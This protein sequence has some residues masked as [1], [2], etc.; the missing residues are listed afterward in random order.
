MNP[1][2]SAS[3]NPRFDY[4]PGQPNLYLMMRHKQEL[5]ASHGVEKGFAEYCATFGLKNARLERLRLDGEREYAIAKGALYSELAAAGE[6]FSHEPPLVIGA[7]NH[8]RIEAISRAQYVACITDA[9]VRGRSALVRTGGA[10]LLD[11]QDREWNLLDDELDWDADI[12]HAEADRYAWV[13]A[14]EDRDML[15]VTEAFSLLGAHTDFFGHWMSEYLPRYIADVLSGRLPVAPV[16]IDSHMPASHR[17]AL[18]MLLPPGVQMIEV[19]AFRAVQVDRLWCRPSFMY[20]PLH[21]K[22]NERFNWAIVAAPAQRFAPVIRYMRQRAVRPDEARG[23][24]R[25][26]LARKSFRHRRLENSAE[27]EALARSRGF[28]VAYPEDLDFAS[29]ARLL[30]N[31][32]LVIALEGSA[33]FLVFFAPPGA[34]LCILSHP[35]TDVLAEYNGIFGTQGISTM[36][37][38][39]PVSKAHAQTPHDSDYRVD[40]ADFARA[41]DAM[42]AA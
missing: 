30:A 2:P 5:V 38:T 14:R 32:K 42:G 24:E 28:E 36:A 18:E 26:F 27:I 20:M 25:V 1:A 13:I 19:P 12:F 35:L 3:G 6:P 16:L 4:A 7:G 21:E 22:R 41:L 9:R 11:V 8:R 37:L 31:A 23:P 17:Q 34:R 33:L 15:R 29:Q 10:A 39:G 40:L